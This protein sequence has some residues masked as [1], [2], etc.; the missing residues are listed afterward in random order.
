MNAYQ[1]EKMLF[2]LIAGRTGK[3]SFSGIPPAWAVLPAYVYSMASARDI[4]A[5][6]EPGQIM[7]EATYIIKVIAKSTSWSA[8]AT[9]ADTLD[10]ALDGAVYEQDGYRL[11][12]RRERPIAYIE[13]DNGQEYRHL[14]GYYTVYLT[15]L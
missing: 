12:V 2:E 3:F 10:S 5:L 9:W 11:E 1:I 4:N 8:V 6:G 7:V 13:I 15:R 14:G